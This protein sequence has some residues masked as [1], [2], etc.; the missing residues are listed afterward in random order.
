MIVIAKARLS[1]KEQNRRA[2]C[3]QRAE[4][5]F[6]SHCGRRPF[7]WLLA[8]ILRRWPVSAR[9]P[10]YEDRLRKLFRRETGRVPDEESMPGLTM[11]EKRPTSA[12]CC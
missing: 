6:L 2:W 5:W 7:S 4:Y 8:R 12:D 9:D 11:R 3:K 10:G 1:L